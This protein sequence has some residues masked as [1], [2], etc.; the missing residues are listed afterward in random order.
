MQVD[1][2][3]ALAHLDEFLERTSPGYA[4]NAGFAATA[5]RIS[6]DYTQTRTID[7][8]AAAS[9]AYLA[10]FGPRAIVAVAHALS[11]TPAS[12]L[13]HVVDL[14][15]GS[16]ASALAWWFAGA[17]KVTL[18]ERSAKALALA[19]QLHAGRNVE[20][21]QHSVFDAISVVDASHVS[22]AFVV[23]ELPA[24]TDL[25]ALLR[26]LAPTAATA[27]LVDAGDQPRARRLQQLRNDLVLDAHVELHGPCPHRDACPAL[28]RERDWCHDRVPKTLPPRLAR[29][30]RLVGRDDAAM[31][32][33][34][35]SW[36]HGVPAPAQ[37]N[38][39][40]VVGE[41]RTEKGRVRVPVCGP[42]GVRFVQVLKRDKPAY[43]VAE[44][45]ERG[46]RLPTPSAPL[47]ASDTLHLADV[48][49]FG[50]FPADE[51]NAEDAS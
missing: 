39:I 7:D 14:G 35:L 20:L 3:A 1:V 36:S 22:A 51:V 29:F 2:A 49:D 21:R 33:S 32:L 31:S 30:A 45:L 16:G 12:S 17:K 5:R 37:A 43:R 50:T 46:H 41:P 28:V 38:G 24:D 26:R 25:T 13:R 19:R 11:H 10:H 40:I 9:L 23:G 34:W 47:S 27:I 42:G 44:A 48:A 15:A 4:D 8:D 18:V 6:V